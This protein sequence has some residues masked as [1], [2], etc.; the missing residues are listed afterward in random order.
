MQKRLWF[1]IVIMLMLTMLIGA[2]LI[3]APN[4]TR[5]DILNNNINGLSCLQNSDDNCLVMPSVTGLT[6]DSVEVNYPEQFVAEYQLIVMP[7]DREQQVLAVTW[8]PLFQ[9]LA[10]ENNNLQYWSI[11][12]L[13]EL[14]AGIRFLVLTGIR[15]AIP[16]ADMRQQV[17]V[18]FLEQQ[19]QF[20]ATLAIDD[21]EAIQA[22]I[23]DSDGVIYYRA[24]GE[25]TEEKGEALRDALTHLLGDG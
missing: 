22:F 2:V 13:P 12:A 21:D 18:L 5:M 19:E 6:S 14:N 3:F 9:E 11:A 23:M 1:I 20:L 17:T 8:L 16:N 15:A 7:F 4:S 10:S 25:F 24:I